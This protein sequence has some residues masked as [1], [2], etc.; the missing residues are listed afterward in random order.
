M[1]SCHAV[2]Q[3]LGASEKQKRWP[4]LSSRILILSDVSSSQDHVASQGWHTARSM[5]MPQRFEMQRRKQTDWQVRNAS[6]WGDWLPKGWASPAGECE[7]ESKSSNRGTPGWQYS[8][9]ITTSFWADALCRLWAR[10][11]VPTEAGVQTASRWWQT[12]CLLRG[13][14]I[15]LTVGLSPFTSPVE[16]RSQEPLK[17]LLYRSYFWVYN[18]FK[19]LVTAIDQPSVGR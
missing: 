9:G 11:R 7:G 1:D 4:R 18:S 14:W 2:T 13:S 6:W 19:N 17:P 10:L 15:L 3:S 16:S 5:D 8:T 12:C